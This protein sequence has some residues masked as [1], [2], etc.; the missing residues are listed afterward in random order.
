MD[1]LARCNWQGF[2]RPHVHT[3]GYREKAVQ[4]TPQTKR[5][6]F[7]AK[8][9]APLTALAC[10][11]WLATASLAFLVPHFL[12]IAGCLLGGSVLAFLILYRWTSRSPPRLRAYR[13]IPLKEL[14]MAFG[15]SLGVLLIPSHSGLS[16]QAHSLWFTCTLGLALGNLIL[17]ARFETEINR[18]SD[19][20]SYHAPSH[21]AWLIWL[22]FSAACSA[23]PLLILGV[24]PAAAWSCILGF[25]TLILDRFPSAAP[26]HHDLALLSVWLV[27]LF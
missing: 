14:A 3:R 25:I 2:R 20:Q 26:W 11:S 17:T 9:L 5:H 21:F 22:A 27:L 13:L 6:L 4:K 18:Q 19:P 7:T 16:W 24:T 1:R 23:S 15:F 10:F 8:H 12:F